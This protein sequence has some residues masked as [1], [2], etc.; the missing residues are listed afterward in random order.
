MA[1]IALLLDDAPHP[2]ELGPCARPRH[3]PD[4][5]RSG[6]EAAGHQLV[7]GA[8]DVHVVDVERAADAPAGD[9]PVVLCSLTRPRD[10]WHAIADA[11]ERQPFIAPWAADLERRKRAALAL[12]AAAY[13]DSMA[14]LLAAIDACLLAAAPEP[15][16]LRY[17]GALFNSSVMRPGSDFPLGAEPRTFV[18]GRGIAAD[19]SV[20]TPQLARA[21]LQLAVSGGDAVLV[22]DLGGTNGT[23]LCEPGG[24]VVALRA[25][26][27][28]RARSGALLL[29]DGSFRFLVL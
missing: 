21:H 15:P 20:P 9:R 17:R 22:T 4:E 3:Q 26:D 11:G 19:V 5:V 18:L 2:A 1:R 13:A 24:A 7:D 25:G 10:P 14:D 6:L 29:P 12:R 28:V 23:W 16:A 8:A 27:P